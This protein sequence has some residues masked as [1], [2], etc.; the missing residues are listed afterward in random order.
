[1]Y[2]G[3]RTHIVGIVSVHEYVT[4]RDREALRKSL[5]PPYS[6]DGDARLSDVLLQMREGGR[7]MAVIRDHAGAAMGMTTLDDVLNRLVGVIVD[8][9]D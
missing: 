2:R 6:V 7:H 1:V 4:A 8:E 3:D 9:F 5:R